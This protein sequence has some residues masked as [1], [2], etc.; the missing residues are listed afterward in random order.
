MN[1]DLW[2]DA[3]SFTSSRGAWNPGRRLSKILQHLIRSLL[4]A[5]SYNVSPGEE[6]ESDRR[7]FRPDSTR[8]CHT[9]QPDL[10]CTVRPWRIDNVSLCCAQI[11]SIS[12]LC[13][14]A[15]PI[16]VQPWAEY[17]SR[18]RAMCAKHSIW[19]VCVYG[20]IKS[21]HKYQPASQSQLDETVTKPWNVIELA[22]LG[23]LLSLGF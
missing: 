18:S 16:M 12:L 22:F 10:T 11:F 17:V 7:S 6:K 20:K 14:S 13:V 8:P 1:N 23:Q 2:D 9:E 19:T 4:Y 21:R 3:T 5:T 15:H